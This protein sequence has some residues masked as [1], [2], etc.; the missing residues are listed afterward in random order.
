MQKDLPPPYSEAAN[1]GFNVPPNPGPPHGFAGPPPGFAGPPP[2]FPGHAPN[3][4]VYP[5]PP[6]ASVVVTNVPVMMQTF[7]P[8]PQPMTCPSCHQQTTTRVLSE[9]STKTHLLALLLCF[10]GCV[11]CCLLPYCLDTCQNQ[12]H[13]CSNCSAYLGVYNDA[14]VYQQRRYW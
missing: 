6:A 13:Y 10:V 9:P 1:V 2:G 4:Q 11:P 3:P 5:G 12:N 7:G 14:A 8:Y